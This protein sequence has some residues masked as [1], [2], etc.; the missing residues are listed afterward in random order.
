[1][2]GNF[3][4]QF[5]GFMVHVRMKMFTLYETKQ[6]PVKIYVDIFFIWKT[7]LNNLR[8]LYLSVF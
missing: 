8:L 4:H 6:F 1:M 2:K 7:S 3:M 5:Y